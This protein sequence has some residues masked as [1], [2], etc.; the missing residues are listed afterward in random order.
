MEEWYRQQIFF[1]EERLQ[2][3]INW[4]EEDKIEF[5]PEIS[6]ENLGCA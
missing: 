6:L 1:T 2:A 5:I 3:I 4:T